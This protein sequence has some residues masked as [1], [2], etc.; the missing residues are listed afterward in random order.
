MI[1][2]HRKLRRVCQFGFPGRFSSASEAWNGVED[3]QTY[4]NRAWTWNGAPVTASAIAAKETD[5]DTWAAGLV[6]T[7]Q[8]RTISSWADQ[9]PIIYAVVKALNRASND[10][11][12]LVPNSALS[13]SALISIIKANLP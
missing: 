6:G 3:I 4:I 13:T 7:E 10:P 11:K 12:A 5:Y 2:T 1:T 8:N 9:N